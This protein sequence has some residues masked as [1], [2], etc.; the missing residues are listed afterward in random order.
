MNS[1]LGDLGVLNKVPNVFLSTL[2]VFQLLKINVLFSSQG[3]NEV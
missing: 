2:K 1:T 3:V